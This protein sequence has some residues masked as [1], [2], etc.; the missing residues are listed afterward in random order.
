MFEQAVDV[1]EIRI[2]HRV[3]QQ[4]Q[5]LNMFIDNPSST[6]R[7]EHKLMKCKHN[8]KPIEKLVHINCK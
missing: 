2:L 3:H 7:S 6:L 8:K 4:L 1:I 5:L